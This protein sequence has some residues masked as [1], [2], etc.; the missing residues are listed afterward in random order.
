MQ[1]PPEH[2][3]AAAG[4]FTVQANNGHILETLCCPHG[5]LVAVAST[6]SS[7]VAATPASLLRSQLPHVTAPAYGLQD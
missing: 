1:S 6:L 3:L 7:L 5:N 4:P 2:C